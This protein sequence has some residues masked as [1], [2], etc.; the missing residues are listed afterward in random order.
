MKRNVLATFTLSTGTVITEVSTVYREYDDKGE[1]NA[2]IVETRRPDGGYVS[3]DP[4]YKPDKRFCDYSAN[5][6]I[7]LAASRCGWGLL[8]VFA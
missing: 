7:E 8:K 5:E 4:D 2:H 6:A 3:G 1:D